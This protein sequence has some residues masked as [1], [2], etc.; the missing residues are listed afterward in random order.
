[1]LYVNDSGT[2]KI[3]KSTD[4][5]YT[6][7]SWR[8]AP[9]A[10]IN[11]WVVEDGSTIYCATA[12]GFW[13][14][15]RFGPA[16]TELT[17]ISLTSVAVV[18]DTVVVGGAGAST[19]YVSFDGGEN[20]GTA[21]AIPLSAASDVYVAFDAEY[22]VADADG[23]NLV[24][25]ATADGVVY[26]CQLTNSA[27]DADKV[28]PVS[29]TSLTGPVVDSTS[30]VAGGTVYN[31]IIVADDNALY[32][33]GSNVRLGATFTAG[34]A[35]IAA[36]GKIQLISDVTAG[37]T[38]ELTFAA[39]TPILGTVGTFI[40]GEV[41]L[42]IGD[43]LVATAATTASGTIQ[44]QGAT[45]RATGYITLSVA[46]NTITNTSGVAIVAN[47]TLSVTSSNMLCAMTGGASASTLG[48]G[49][50][51]LLLHERANVW[52]SEANAGITSG[53]WYSNG[54]NIL[55]VVDSSSTLEA[56][57]DFLSG[58]VQGVTVTEYQGSPNTATK[59]VTVGWTQLRGA[60]LGYDRHH[61]FTGK[62]Y[63]LYRSCGFEN[64]RDC[65]QH[66]CIR[67]FTCYQVRILCT[68]KC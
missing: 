35:N 63:N 62:H 26:Q 37:A 34:T 56:F 17:G 30:T 60:T 46:N 67:A 2:Y 40:D 32:L 65:S 66:N 57:E 16:T 54:S 7:T 39:A 43:N 13:G 23:E 50:Q 6:Y 53:L 10:L 44:V 11:D 4:G 24:Y 9:A 59:T 47:D 3:Y 25:A 18:D 49:M 12:S 55:W 14:T 28:V 41:L 29:A 31:S 36:G 5:G 51:R 33:S 61:S 58:K 20:W 15:S 22:G 64:C 48:A 8:S 45:S 38:G 52:E 19:I 68:C 1:M 21:F 42:V 27:T